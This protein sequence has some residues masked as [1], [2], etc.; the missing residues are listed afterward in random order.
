MM[1]ASTSFRIGGTSSMDRA[2]NTSL[3]PTIA[4]KSGMPIGPVISRTAMTPRWAPGRV[5]QAASAS[6][7][8]AD[9]WVGSNLRP[10]LGALVCWT[11]VNPTLATFPRTTV[12]FR[13][14]RRYVNHRTVRKSAGLRNTDSALDARMLGSNISGAAKK[15]MT[16]AGGSH[17]TS[18]TNIL[19]VG[20]GGGAPDPRHRPDDRECAARRRSPQ[21]HAVPPLGRLRTA[22]VA[23][24]SRVRRPRHRA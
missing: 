24:T 19:G 7:S 15:M 12:K 4:V 18:P 6:S 8:R 21:G 17:L 23:R 3:P 16:T 1:A 11:A 22:R 10:C 13:D 5:P 20:S 9:S 14:S 2:R